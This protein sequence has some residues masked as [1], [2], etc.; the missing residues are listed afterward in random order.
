[1]GG[2]AQGL[3]GYQP[4]GGEHYTAYNVYVVHHLFCTSSGLYL[5]YEFCCFVFFPD[6]LPHLYGENE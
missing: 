4:A 1:M 6:A 3:A 2:T 5:E